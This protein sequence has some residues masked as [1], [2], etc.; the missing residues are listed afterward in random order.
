MNWMEGRSEIGREVSTLLSGCDAEYLSG[1]RRYWGSNPHTLIG[2]SP[3]IH[4]FNIPP[5]RI[6]FPTTAPLFFKK[7]GE[8]HWKQSN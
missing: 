3:H 5:G 4:F 2:R 6:F 8:T 7:R 1:M